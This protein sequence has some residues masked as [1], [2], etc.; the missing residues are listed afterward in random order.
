MDAKN[1]LTR[2]IGKSNQTMYKELYYIIKWDLSQIYKTCSTFKRSVSK[3]YLI[4][5]I[6]KIY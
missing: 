3:L 6:N 1:P 5:I 2:Y 4:N